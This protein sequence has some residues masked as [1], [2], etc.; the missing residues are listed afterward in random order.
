M[1]KDL[2]KIREDRG[3]ADSKVRQLIDRTL[4][5]NGVDRRASHGGDFTGVACLIMEDRIDKI[6][7]E[8]KLILVEEG[9]RNT[10]EI[11]EYCQAFR[12]HFLLLSHMFSLARTSKK[13]FR[14]PEKKAEV[15][16]Q[17]KVV[18]PLVNKSTQRLGLSME[19]VK[20]HLF[21]DHLLDMITAHD[22]IAEYLEDWVEQ[23]HQ[24]YKKSISR[25]KMRDLVQ[26]ANY[27]CKEDK[28]YHNEGVK[29][30]QTQVKNA[31]ARQFV[32]R[33]ETTFSAQMKSNARHG[34]RL[35]AVTEATGLFAA[36]PM[37]RS[38]LEMNLLAQ[39][40]RLEAESDLELLNEGD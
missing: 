24:R 16:A 31:R 32:N 27:Q 1:K 29:T 36:F 37:M 14:I 23:I 17:L 3:A 38:A 19:T 34:R 12:L 9:N 4:K 28:V 18:I 39:R 10:G 25:G 30:V 20:R 8:F 15:I 33:G 26:R 2:Q 22:G 35:R 11:D 40:S 21:S 13:E 6:M 5:S 7:D